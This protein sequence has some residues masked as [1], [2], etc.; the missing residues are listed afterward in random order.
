MLELAFYCL[1][2][3]SSINALFLVELRRR[4]NTPALARNESSGFVLLS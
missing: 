1:H 3:Q 4:L 2:T